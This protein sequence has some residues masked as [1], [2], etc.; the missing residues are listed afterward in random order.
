MQ[1]TVDY[2]ELQRALKLARKATSTRPAL[3]ILGGVRLEVNRNRGKLELTSTDLEISV[4]TILDP[5]DYQRP[6]AVV[7]P[8]ASLATAVKD[9][10]P[11]ATTVT[12]RTDSNQLRVEL[13]GMSFRLRTLDLDNWPWLDLF[14]I[15]SAD[16]VLVTS[17]L[18]LPRIWAE[19][20]APAASDD[21]ARPVLNGVLVERK[22]G[23]Q[24]S[25]VTAAATDS[26]RLHVY[27]AAESHGQE[28]STLVPAAGLRFA[29]D[30]MKA[31]K[32][33]DGAVWRLERA[34]TVYARFEVGQSTI[35][36]RCIDGEFPDF[37]RL[38]PSADSAT[39]ITIT[40][41]KAAAGALK[42]AETQAQKTRAPVVLE[43]SGAE[44]VLATITVQDVGT[45]EIPVPGMKA[46][47]P[48]DAVGF[49]PGFL[50]DAILANGE[51][52]LH[53]RPDLA[54]ALLDSGDGFRALVMPVRIP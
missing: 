15:V 28:T 6:D 43:R 12:L 54:P 37:E 25:T 39:E 33:S 51:G 5:V 26:Y 23:P 40:D 4:K 22:V 34:G 11:K 44:T 30:A 36:V 19:R 52:T 41:A 1:V 48:F 3:P 42:T 38:M 50:R 16:D 53:L 47:D 10:R 27:Q 13:D 31:H 46:P 9:P 8:V 24:Y 21:E 29:L 45:C 35:V 18:E 2:A 49:A 14:D 20:V 17:D 7:V 32:T